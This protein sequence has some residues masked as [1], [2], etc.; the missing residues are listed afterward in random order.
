MNI[1]DLAHLRED[2]RIKFKEELVSGETF[3]IVSY[4]IADVSLWE[5]PLAKE[6]RGITFN[7][8]GECVSRPFEKFFSVGEN[9]ENQLHNII[10]TGIIEILEK[11]DGSMLTPVLVGNGVFFKTKKSFVSDVALVADVMAADYPSITRFSE[12]MLR[13]GWTPIFEF[14]SSENVVVIDYGDFQPFTLLAL[15]RTV[16]GE[17]MSHDELQPLCRF[18]HV[19]LITSYQKTLDDVLFDKSFLENF[20]GYVLVL[21]D[22]RRVKLKTDWYIRNHRIRTDLRERDVAEMVADEN[23][24][25]LKIAASNE[26]YDLEPIVAIETQVV[27]ELSEIRQTVEATVISCKERS[28]K[29]VALDYNGHQLFSLIMTAFRGKDPDYVKYWKRYFLGAYS[30]KSIYNPKFSS[31]S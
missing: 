10:D 15:R 24:D 19:P 18:Y 26:K 12:D 28:V 16:S 2:S 11:R 8:K 14:T 20:E 6:C 1:N 27:K 23:V 9:E 3:T 7:Q 22:G 5:I 13:S 21:A 31:G 30:L 4:M 29:E 25:E 17:Y